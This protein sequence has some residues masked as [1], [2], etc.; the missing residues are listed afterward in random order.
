MKFCIKL[1]IC[2]SSIKRNLKTTIKAQLCSVIM[3]L[4]LRKSTWQQ[5]SY[6]HF[7]SAAQRACLTFSYHWFLILSTETH[8]RGEK[9]KQGSERWRQ[10]VSAVVQWVRTW[11][12][13]HVGSIP[14]LAQWVKDL[15]VLQMYH[16]LQ[17]QL[18]FDPW[19]VNTFAMGKEKK[20]ERK[21]EERKNEGN[22]ERK[23]EGG[24]KESWRQMRWNTIEIL[25]LLLTPNLN[26]R[27]PCSDIFPSS[28]FIPLK[29]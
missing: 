7:I 18:R 6:F 9:R 11:Q 27:G 22:K 28:S 26:F 20:R 29:H 4:H 14:S 19:P 2:I 21:K 10:G 3:G 13:E 24:K 15:A 17:L 25:V 8:S 16:R 23:M 1:Q 12:C 5:F